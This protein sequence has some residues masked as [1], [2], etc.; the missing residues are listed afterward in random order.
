MGCLPFVGKFRLVS[1]L[2]NVKRFSK[3]ADQPD[4]MALTI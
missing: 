1:P 3:N 4:E 2:H